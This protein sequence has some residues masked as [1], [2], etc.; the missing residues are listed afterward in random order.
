MKILII[1]DEISI[2][3]GMT[4]AFK[5]FAPEFEIIAFCDPLCVVPFI[6]K[7][8]VDLVFTDIK[9]PEMSGVELTKLLHNKFPDLYIIVLSAYSDF[10]FVRS[11]L[12]NGAYDYIL[13]P[14]PYQDI[15]E[16]TTQINDL[17]QS[18]KKSLLYTHTNITDFNA[19]LDTNSLPPLPIYIRDALDYINKNYMNDISLKQVAD[20]IHHNQFYLSSRFKKAVQMSFV[21]YLNKVRIE[22]SKYLLRTENLKI[23]DIAYIVGFKES[24][25]F[26][27]VFKR[28]EGVSPN[29]YRANTAK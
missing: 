1:D 12:K 11:C 28:I 15:L 3:D 5:K 13:K 22:H 14:T 23:S 9:M 10:N 19:F 20:E 17:I 29:T 4:Y 7:N 6:E 8:K 16:M 2:V 25:Y 27:T 21:E 24:T 26:C 18:H